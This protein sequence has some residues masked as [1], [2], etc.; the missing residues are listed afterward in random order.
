[1]EELKGADLSTLV[2]EEYR[3]EA[4]RKIVNN[5]DAIVNDIMNSSPKSQDQIDRVEANGD[6]K[7]AI[8]EM[9][10]VVIFKLLMTEF[11]GRN[12][13]D[14]LSDELSV[15]DLYSEVAKKGAMVMAQ[16]VCAPRD[17][18]APAAKALRAA[19]LSV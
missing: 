11:S 14:D 17:M 4:A 3:W 8:E 13:D 18:S 12:D 7:E 16:R 2:E 9:L 6:N 1:L 10:E 19:L 5:K 15:S